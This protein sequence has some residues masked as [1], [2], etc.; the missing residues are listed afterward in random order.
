MASAKSTKHPKLPTKV[1][2]GAQDWTIVERS[3]DDDG[4]IN[5]D[6]YGYTLQ[7]SNFIVI[8]KNCPPSRKRQT[9]FHELFHAVRFSNG[10]SGIKPDME[11]ITADDV[12]YTWE[13]YFI[14]MYEDTM[15]SV[16]RENPAV[17]EYLLSN[18]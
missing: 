5:D 16:F 14:A 7:K 6:S 9:L 1:K 15:L 10:S 11:N 2:I 3:R 13:H 18:E 4:M 8:D 12:I 17:V